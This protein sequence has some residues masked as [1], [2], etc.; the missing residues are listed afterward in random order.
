MRALYLPV[1]GSGNWGPMGRKQK[2]R[3]LAIVPPAAL[4]GATKN[5]VVLALQPPLPEAIVGIEVG[6]GTGT[7]TGT[8]TGTASGTETGIETGTGIG[9]ETGN[10]T[11]T[12]TGTAT[13]TVK[14]LSAGQTLSPSAGPL[15]RGTLSTCTEKI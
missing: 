8:G 5:G 11:E 13:A 7:E 3:A 9:T 15:V 4:T 6:R 2:A 14:A 1:I 12:G 10:G